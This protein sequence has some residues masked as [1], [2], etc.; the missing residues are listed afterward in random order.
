MTE[1]P[2]VGHVMRYPYLWA[3][4]AYSGET[5][6]RKTR[7]CA[8]VLAIA[9]QVG[10]TELRLCAITTQPPSPTNRA[11]SV[12]EMERRRAGLDTG[13]DLWVILDEHNLDVYE[14]SFYI[15]P[16]SHLGAFSPAF[17]KAL[18]KGMIQVLRDRISKTVKRSD[19]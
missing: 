17:T 4:Q 11:I 19:L 16:Q 2:R 7:P 8:V 15:E 9:D 6:G 1:A 18:Q 5:E 12:P 13:I 10:Q 14:Q 3:R